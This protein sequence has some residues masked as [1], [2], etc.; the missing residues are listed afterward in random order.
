MN[1]QTIHIGFIPLVD[2]A[3]LIIAKE[4][5]WAEQNHIDLILHKEVS[6]ANIRDKVYLGHLQGAQMLAGMALAARLGVMLPSP[7]LIVPFVLGRNGNAITVSN[8]ILAEMCHE[9]FNQKDIHS[10]LITGQ[11]LKRVIEKRKSTS[12]KPLRFGMVFPFSNHNYHLRNWMSECGINPDLDVHL[13]VIPPP[14]MDKRLEQNLIDGFCVGEPWN[15]LAVEQGIGTIIAAT[16]DIHP[17]CPEKVL[18]L[19]KDWCDGN[20]GQLANLIHT[21]EQSSLWVAQKDNHAELAE[22]LSSHLYLDLPK[23]II[24]RSLSGSLKI[25]RNEKNVSFNN[26]ICLGGHDTTTP[27]E[28]DHLWLYEQ[29][30]KWNHVEN[31][32]ANAINAA[33][34]FTRCIDQ[35]AS[36]ET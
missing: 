9:G 23:E 5:G 35:K 17:E 12:E 34:L 8:Q 24:L 25:K 30:T 6:W 2:C 26:F 21:L 7:E 10:P 19:R 27:K 13:E 1:K 22:I 32:N 20:Q 29:M 15:S 36:S 16:S 31:N 33:A 28:K 3:T 11:A 4:K 18:G 14:Y